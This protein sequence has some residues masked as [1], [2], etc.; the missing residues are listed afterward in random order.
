MRKWII[1]LLLLLAVGGVLAE[2]RQLLYRAPTAA[3]GGISSFSDIANL[4]AVY[5]GNLLVTNSAGNPAADGEKL[6]S[7]GDSSGN[8][9]HAFTNGVDTTYE[10]APSMGTNKAI[11]MGSFRAGFTALPDT[12]I[13]V[14]VRVTAL[15][16]FIAAID[17]TNS[18]AAQTIYKDNAD[19]PTIYSGTVLAPA[20][21]AM[22]LNANHTLIAT[23][24]SGGNDSLYTNGV[25]CVTGDSGNQSLDG[26]TLGDLDAQT[27]PWGDYVGLIVIYNRI[28]N[29]TEI[30][31]I[32][33]LAVA[34]GWR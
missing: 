11:R 16:S 29:S 17:S 5:D 31:Q 1:S 32:D 26:A 13:L 2:R 9:H 30:A 28:L 34:R 21:G 27:I 3:S 19:L 4:F 12:T 8:G 22:S 14:A 6:L 15:G 23:F 10:S 18:A 24:N 20:S 7:W 33:A 25:L